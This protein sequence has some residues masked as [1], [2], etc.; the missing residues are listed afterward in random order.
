MFARALLWFV[1][2]YFFF[3]L[4]ELIPE[5]KATFKINLVSMLLNKFVLGKEQSSFDAKIFL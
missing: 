3:Q 1:K 5:I 2:Y 4:E